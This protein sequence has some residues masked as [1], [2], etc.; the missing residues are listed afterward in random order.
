[1]PDT[2]F[3]D[4]IVLSQIKD[5]GFTWRGNLSLG[6]FTR[7]QQEIHADQ[8]SDDLWVSVDLIAGVSGLFWLTLRVRG[9]LRLTCQRCLEGLIYPLSI[10]NRVAVLSSERLVE[11]MD[12]SDD[13]VLVAEIE[14][15]DQTEAATVDL[16][17]VIEDE[18]LLALPA[19]PKH[20]DCAAAKTQ[21]GDIDQ[22]K[23][24]NPF[25]QLSQ[26]KK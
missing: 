5:S 17:Q 11:L 13:Y 4:R 3:I 24:D 26:L 9:E 2:P 7:L 19:S 18:C 20:D 15:P 14:A 12:E 23:P 10:D 22:I 16:F 8:P 25:A 21:A 6:R 1:M